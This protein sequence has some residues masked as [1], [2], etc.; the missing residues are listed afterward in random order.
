MKSLDSC[1]QHTW[2]QKS[3]ISLT[4]GNEAWKSLILWAHKENNKLK[5]IN[6][7]VTFH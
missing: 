5:K 7:F 3:L 1:N 6:Y 4:H 2:I